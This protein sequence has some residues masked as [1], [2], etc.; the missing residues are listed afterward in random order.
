MSHSMCN[1]HHRH[2]NRASRAHPRH[3][4]TV[5]LLPGQSGPKAV[6]ISSE[7]VLPPST[8]THINSITSTHE[9]AVGS[10]SHP[11]VRLAKAC[12]L[13]AAAGQGTGLGLCK[14][15]PPTHKCTCGSPIP[16]PVHLR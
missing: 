16:L 10:P 7:V 11:G 5:P 12:S 9:C 15:H 1:A 4:A 6:Q 2:N 13:R 3:A 14:S 8:P